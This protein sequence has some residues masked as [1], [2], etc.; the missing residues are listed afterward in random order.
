MP[1]TIIKDEHWTSILLELNIY[2][3]ENL[4]NTVEGILYQIRVCSPW[5]NLH[6]CFDELNTGYKAYL[7]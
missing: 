5:H 2:D 6:E 7:R 3:K 4:R 1:R